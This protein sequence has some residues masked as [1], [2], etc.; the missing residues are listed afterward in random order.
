MQKQ[1]LR[2]DRANGYGVLQHAIRN[3]YAQQA[4]GF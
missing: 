4:R 1:G 3:L 2:F